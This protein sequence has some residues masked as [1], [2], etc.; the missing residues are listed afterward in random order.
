MIYPSHRGKQQ[1]LDEALVSPNIHGQC[2][3]GVLEGDS[4]PGTQVHPHLCEKVMSLRQRS[5][6]EGRPVFYHQSLGNRQ[7]FR[8][9]SVKAT[10]ISNTY[11]VFTDYLVFTKYY[12]LS[13]KRF[14][15]NFYNDPMEI[16][17][18]FTLFC[19]SET[20]IPRRCLR[21]DMSDQSRE[22][23]SKDHPPNCSSMWFFPSIPFHF[24][25]GGVLMDEEKRERSWISKCQTTERGAFESLSAWKP[26][27]AGHICLCRMA[28]WTLVQ[29]ERPSSEEKNKETEIPYN[30]VKWFS[31]S[32]LQKQAPETPII[33]PCQY[34]MDYPTCHHHA[35]PSEMYTCG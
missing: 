25:E 32:K 4:N 12:I 16:G 24:K 19:N 26:K 31:F 33:S 5:P 29:P 3:G 14:T 18:I 22:C 35:S 15:F 7:T 30:W 17:M 23:S 1:P 20:E 6:L 21:R 28:W 13:S 9:R 11:R 34:S 10:I 8:G 27:K 2:N